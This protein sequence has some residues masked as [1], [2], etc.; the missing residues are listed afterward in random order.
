M[1]ERLCMESTWNL[2]LLN[3]YQ[4]PNMTTTAFSESLH[5]VLLKFLIELEFKTEHKAATM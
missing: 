3:H 4:G 5:S 2:K 1:R